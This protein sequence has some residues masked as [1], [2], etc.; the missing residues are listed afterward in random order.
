M[1]SHSTRSSHLRR[2]T[3][4]R[5]NCQKL[6]SHIDSLNL[7]SS[8]YNSTEVGIVRLTLHQAKELDSS[9]SLTGDLNPFAK[10]LLS[11]RSPPVHTTQRFKHTISPVWESS[12]EWLCSDRGS[13]V[14]TIKVIDDRDF[15]KDPVIGFMS[16]RLDDLLQAKKEAGRDWWP[17]SGCKSGK[18]RLSVEW[19]PL[20]MAGS[21]HGA[22]QYV[23][24]IGI[25]RLW[26]Q[27]ATDV[28]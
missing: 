19:K 15:L 24:P 23:P 27:K 17:L 20:N 28:K 6:V 25:V 11:A 10:V 18:V 26:V 2:L 1:M 5:K 8:S 3:V 9:K 12:T 14:V 16:V 22:D 4:K 21:L 7:H 13:S